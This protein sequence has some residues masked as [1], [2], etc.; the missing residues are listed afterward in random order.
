MSP[1]RC[2][3]RLGVAALS[4][5]DHSTRT[6]RRALSVWPWVIV[7]AAL[8][9]GGSA[10]QGKQ[11][12]SVCPDDNPAAFHACALAAA[13]AFNPPRT[14]SG[15]PNLAGI[16]RRIA[17]SHEDLEAHPKTIDDGGGPSVVVDPSDGKVPMQPWADAARKEHATK[18]I[19]NNAACL[20][21]GVPAM[22]YVTGMYQVTQT[23]DYLLIQTEE[24][25]AFRLIPMDASPHIG[26]DIRLWLGDSRGRWEGTTLVI[27]TTGQNAKA[28]L[29]QRGRFFTEEARVVERF[30]PIDAGTMHY[31]AT[32]E[33]GNVYTRPWTIAIPFRRNTEAGIELWE[34]ACHEANHSLRHILDAGLGV[35][36][37]ITAKEARERRAA[38]ESRGAGR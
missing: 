37:G 14:S 38:W 4:S 8:L 36:P 28:F 32:I 16:W 33:D 34:E 6:R 17:R 1:P 2:I 15:V 31:Q 27:E 22:M 10:G 3:A 18:F 9:P 21:S 19:H 23:S 29:D 25:H 11:P 26:A 30:T 20:L 24:T 5:H 13:K 12:Q 35:F 7:A